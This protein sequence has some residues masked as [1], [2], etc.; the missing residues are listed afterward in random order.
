VLVAQRYE[1]QALAL[2]G[3]A[4]LSGEVAVPYPVDRPMQRDGQVAAEG[5]QD[6]SVMA[7]IVRSCRH[8][9]DE[10]IAVTVWSRARPTVP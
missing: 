4:A 6:S 2:P 8:R 5:G 1:P 9:L 7:A 10:P 3:I